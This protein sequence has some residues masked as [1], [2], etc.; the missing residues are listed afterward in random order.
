LGCP[1]ADLGIDR[2]AVL[3]D[4]GHEFAGEGGSV[5]VAFLLGQ[6]AFE[7]GVRRALAEVRLEDRREGEAPT[8]PPAADAVSPR[9][10]R[11]G[12]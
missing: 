7:D 1:S 5:L 8:G 4:R 6:M 3:D 10:R 12:R 9:H 11:P 2:V